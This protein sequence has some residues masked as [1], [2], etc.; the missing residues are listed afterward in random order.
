MA[1]SDIG[2]IYNAQKRQQQEQEQE[3]EIIKNQLV[4]EGYS[5]KQVEKAQKRGTF[6]EKKFKASTIRKGLT[7]QLRMLRTIKQKLISGKMSADEM[8]MLNDVEM[9]ILQGSPLTFQPNDPILTYFGQQA[10]N[11]LLKSQKFSSLGKNVRIKKLS[12]LARK[13]ASSFG[14]VIEKPSPIKKTT[15]RAKKVPVRRTSQISTPEQIRTLTSGQ[16]YG[17]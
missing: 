4:E 17:Y 9:A 10:A 12:S 14:Y 1:P 8:P 13:Y 6:S 16:F 15:K 7:S 2:Q 5:P 11:K 3:N